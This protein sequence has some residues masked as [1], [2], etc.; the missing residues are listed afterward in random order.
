L[1]KRLREVYALL[2][3]VNFFELSE[4]VKSA[5]GDEVARLLGEIVKLSTELRDASSAGQ[6][7]PPKTTAPKSEPRKPKGKGAKKGSR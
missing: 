3:N 5:N 4:E 6:K 1:L 2:R 7:K